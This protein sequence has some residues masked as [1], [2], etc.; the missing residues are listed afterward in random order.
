MFRSANLLAH[1]V[2]FNSDASAKLLETYDEVTQAELVAASSEPKHRTFAPS[3]FRCDR[4]SW[5]RLRGVQP[6]KVAQADT[7]LD[8]TAV[9]GTA[10]HEMIQRRL[11]GTAA[12]LD[13][14]KHLAEHC[15]FPY[16]CESKGY[17]TLIEINDPPVRFAC[18]GLVEIA[19]QR[20]LLEIK[21][22]EYSSFQDLT[23]PKERHIDQVKC[24][25]AL[26]NVENAL[27]LYIDRQYGDMKCFQVRV[28]LYQREDVI[29]R[30]KK[31]MDLA[32][33]RIAPDRL[34]KGDSWCTPSMCPYYQKCKEW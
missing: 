25:C 34:P 30:M 2:K 29:S 1:T 5:F 20:Y 19:G 12:W 4:I 21:S 11:S 8:F 26:I 7:A 18:D 15:L 6:D 14:E 10:C 27:V 17:E 23:E 24:Y 28:P 31:V 9:V 16:T 13:V 32:E 3:Q 22:S 33:A